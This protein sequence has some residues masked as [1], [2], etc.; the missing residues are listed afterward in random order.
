VRTDRHAQIIDSRHR[1]LDRKPRRRQGLGLPNRVLVGP[2]VEPEQRLPLLDRLVGLD[3][4]FREQRRMLQARYEL[5]GVLD[6]AQIRRIRRLEA[7]AD[8]EDQQDMQENDG[9]DDAPADAEI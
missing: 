9:T 7:H 5:D 3:Q 4:D 1:D 6:D 2:P 8:R